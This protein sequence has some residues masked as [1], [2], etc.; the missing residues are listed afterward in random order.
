[1]SKTEYV[2]FSIEGGFITQH[3]RGLV[4]EGNWRKAL[5]QLKEVLIGAS[6]EH[7]IEV[8]NGNCKLTGVNEL[9]MEEDHDSEEY[10]YEVLNMYKN[11]V[12]K[13][14]ITYRVEAKIS[15]IKPGD[16]YIFERMALYLDK[17]VDEYFFHN[18]IFYVANESG[19]SAPIW[20]DYKD[21]PCYDVED[22]V[23]IKM[24]D[25]GSKEELKLKRIDSIIVK[26]A[27]LN[28]VK[29]EDEEFFQE[30]LGQ[31][32]IILNNLK[33]DA[34]KKMIQKIRAT[35]IAQANQKGGFL[36]IEHKGKTFKIPKLPYMH[37]VASHCYNIDER[38][39]Y[40]ENLDDWV[41]ISP[42]GLKMHNDD[43]YHSD[44][45]IGAGF[46]PKDF[47]NSDFSEACWNYFWHVV[48]LDMITI[49]G[50]GI[51]K[52]SVKKVFEHI[53]PADCVDKIIV[54]PHAGV[55]YF[56]HAKVAKLV[57]AAKGGPASHLALNA[58]EYSINL[59]LIEKALG[60]KVEQELV[61]DL[62][63]ST[64]TYSK[65]QKE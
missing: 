37:W 47:Y 29:I 21:L 40:E 13:N 41:A 17:P 20:I 30:E 5:I 14:G 50:S 49:S 43:P 27:I 23:D 65:L 34:D 51:I 11:L 60:F 57:I 19:K 12:E 64:Y 8:L 45:V 28:D 59:V 61:F 9:F 7:C 35:V 39:F 3:F 62:D 32:R 44:Y 36:T 42:L 63:N 46:N 58:E 31:R 16:E 1:M 52:G 15:T 6:D 18:G 24:S 25:N 26:D 38:N 53:D 55:E 2:N 22:L 10:K 33:D 48:R 4:L 56:E 54:I